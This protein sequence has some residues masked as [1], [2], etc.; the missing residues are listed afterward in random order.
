MREYIGILSGSGGSWTVRV[1]D[2]PECQADGETPAEAVRKV[3]D[4]VRYWAAG[5]GLTLP[6]RTA[7]DLAADPE[8]AFDTASEVAVVVSP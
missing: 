8:A 3:T 7:H 6:A 4:V 5:I 1:P 2:I